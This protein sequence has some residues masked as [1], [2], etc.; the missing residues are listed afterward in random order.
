MRVFGVAAG[1]AAGPS[2][3]LSAVLALVLSAGCA[4]RLA[5]LPRRA[6]LAVDDAVE[7]AALLPSRLERCTVVRP[8]RLAARR[9]S[10]AL[11]RT[12]AEPS[13]FAA[14]LPVSAYATAVADTVDGTA[15]RSYYRFTTS[16]PALLRALSALPVR[17]L[18][19][20]CEGLDCQRMVARFIDERT[21][22]VARREWPRRPL[23]LDGAACVQLARSEPGAFELSVDAR[24]AGGSFAF[25]LPQL[26]RIVSSASARDLTTRR[27]EV[28]RDGLEAR[29]RQA[30]IEAYGPRPEVAI[31]QVAALR[32]HVDRVGA[33]VVVTEARRWEELELAVEDE[34]YR[35]RELDLSRARSEPLPL[36]RIDFTNLSVVR[37]QVQLRQAELSRSSG[38]RRDEEVVIFARLLDAAIAAHPTELRFAQTAARLALDE[39]G[40][41]S[42]AIPIVERV[43]ASGLAERPEEWRALERE[44]LSFGPP[45]LLA[46][47]LEAQGLAAGADA[48]RGAED[49]AALRAGGVPYEMAESAWRIGRRLGPERVPRHRVRAQLPWEG[50]LGALAGIARLEGDL[51]LTTLQVAVRVR[52]EGSAQAI[53][54]ERPEVVI[55]RGPSGS[56]FV[57]GVAATTE[58]LALRRLG[59]TLAAAVEPGPVDV[60]VELR[61]PNAERGLTLRVSGVLRGGELEIERVDDALA[62]ARWE[63]VGRYL[64][65]PLVELPTALFPPPELTVR[66]ESSEVAEALRR[67]LPAGACRVAGP[68]LRCTAPGRPEALGE[69]LMQV[70]RARLR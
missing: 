43:I 31:I 34:R 28:M 66:A 17:W 49:L 38:A 52:G 12:Q 33:T 70:A 45:R 56:R 42:S 16:G 5:P 4:P 3:V 13:A 23:P 61:A 35:I 27:I 58:L 6:P 18:D 32:A 7:L 64:A 65:R 30:A 50:V 37:H 25:P 46:A 60:I 14:D 41:A 68:I 24:R 44:A 69:M 54:G 36:A 19:E 1:R 51:G 2:A 20:P 29:A 55:V 39:P 9:R 59:A 11:Q 22:E 67:D 48:L 15:R 63:L 10:L 53:G 62:S 47:E 57:V 8:R 40:R 21:I 26:T